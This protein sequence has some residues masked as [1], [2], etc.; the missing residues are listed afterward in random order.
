MK[1]LDVNILIHAFYRQ[2]PDH[3]TC[4]AYVD[5]LLN[6]AGSFGFS[7]L[8]LSGFL[9]I[10]TNTKV[11]RPAA[12]LVKAV[13]FC[14]VIRAAPNAILLEPGPQHWDLFVD[15]AKRSK[16]A[17]NLIPDAYFAALAMEHG[18]TWV[19]MDRDYARF[20]GL[21]WESPQGSE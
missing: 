14:E 19:T 1:L 15:L 16:A 9:R 7:N 17:G 6:G 12:P 8:V 21:R 5:D 2:S 3:R 10:V 13:E 20:P 11:F 18:C 4:R